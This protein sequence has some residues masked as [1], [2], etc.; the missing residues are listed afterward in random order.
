M[1]QRWSY[2]S[3]NQYLRCPLQFFFQRVL[4]IPPQFTPSGLVLGSSVHESLAAYHRGLKDNKPIAA[5]EITKAFTE[6]WR[7]R[8][9]RETISFDG[10]QS[11]NDIVAQGVALLEVYLKEP[12]PQNVIAVEQEMTAAIHNSDGEVLEKPMT[13]IIDLI[14]QPLTRYKI[15][16]LKTS[17]RC[18]SEM[19]A[20]V[21]LQGTCY[22]NAV[23]RKPGPTCGL[24][25]RSPG[26]NKEA[27]RPTA[28]DNEIRKGLRQTGRPGSECRPSG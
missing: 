22:A 24:R 6:S 13:A 16:D 26:Q 2:S 9:T 14:T 5:E 19:E 7:S 8:K 12:P 28:G 25:V 4:C 3:L 10:R 27:L 23:H 11:E 15:T 17:S 1:I 18:Y 20:A 21:S